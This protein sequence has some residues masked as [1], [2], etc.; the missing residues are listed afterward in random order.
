MKKIL[1]IIIGLVLVVI[2]CII[3]NKWLVTT[4]YKIESKKLPKS[5]DGMRI[6]Q[7]SDLHDATFGNKQDRLIKKFKMQSLMLF[8]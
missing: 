4:T 8:S 6:V 2:F 7:V 5:F 1:R 3:N